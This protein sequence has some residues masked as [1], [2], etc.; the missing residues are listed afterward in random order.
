MLSQK[1]IHAVKLSEK[2]AYQIAHEAGLHPSLI[3]IF[4]GWLSEKKFQVVISTHSIDVLYSLTKLDPKDVKI[5]FLAKS[6]AES[7]AA[8]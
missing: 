4:L 8:C 2:R 3:D 5:L 6:F 1:L 7:P